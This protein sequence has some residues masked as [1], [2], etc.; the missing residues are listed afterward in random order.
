[1][2]LLLVVAVAAVMLLLLVVVAVVILLWFLL[3]MHTLKVIRSVPLYD[4]VCILS[5]VSA[6]RVFVAVF[7]FVLFFLL[8]SVHRLLCFQVTLSVAMHDFVLHSFSSS[9]CT[10]KK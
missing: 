9:I 10:F 3:C 7:C 1:M 5:A 8:Q 4:C 6:T 2:L